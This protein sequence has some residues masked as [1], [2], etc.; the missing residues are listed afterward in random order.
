MFGYTGEKMRLK[1][2]SAVITGSSR[3][4]GEAIAEVFA[5]EGA[6]VIVNCHQEP[7]EGARVVD[8][9]RHA[10]GRAEICMADVRS[11][12]DSERLVQSAIKSYGKI[13]II[14]NNAGIVR[15]SMIEKITPEAWREVIDTNLTGVFNCSK[16]ASGPMKMQGQG[17]IINISSVVAEMGNIGQ[18][19]YAASKGGVISLT[20]ALALELARHG[21]L[22]NAIAPGFCATRMTEAIPETVREKILAKIPLKRFGDPKEIAYA[23]VFLSSDECCYMT[24][25]VLSVNGGLHL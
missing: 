24:G 16:A 1:G 3:G 6:A 9:I 19:N 22:V 21:V 10:G 5:A 13:D 15:D 2:K 23:A 25:Q 18:A 11:P 7:E 17:R 8:R 20:R 14:V 12:E 4:I